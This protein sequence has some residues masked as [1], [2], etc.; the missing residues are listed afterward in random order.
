M[1]NLALAHRVR[2]M[3]KDPQRPAIGVPIE[4][5]IIG[6]IVVGAYVNAWFV[7]F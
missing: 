7:L 5:I 3:R 1:P 4:A 2:D 6:I